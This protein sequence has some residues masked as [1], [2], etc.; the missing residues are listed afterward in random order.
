MESKIEVGES[1]SNKFC[2][3]PSNLGVVFFQVTGFSNKPLSL[4]EP[5]LNKFG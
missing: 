4:Q 3:F 1:E 5:P 2:F